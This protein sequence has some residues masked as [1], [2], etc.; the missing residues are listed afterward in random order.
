MN[1]FAD[2]VRDAVVVDQPRAVRART[3]AS[4]IQAAT[5]ALGRHLYRRQRPRAQR[6]AERSGRARA[7]GLCCHPGP[8]GSRRRS[9]GRRCEQRRRTRPRYL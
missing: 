9:P 8:H 3:A 1:E 7:P 6:G 5:G 4:A 2:R